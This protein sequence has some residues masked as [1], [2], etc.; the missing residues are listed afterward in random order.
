[1]EAVRAA[2]T[3]APERLTG[4]VISLNREAGWAWV[5]EVE[6]DPESAII[7]YFCHVRFV[8]EGKLRRGAR[9]TFVPRHGERGYFASDVKMIGSPSFTS[10]RYTVKIEG[11]VA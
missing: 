8:V 2:T 6:P 5:R 3:V 1:M 10:T 4:V 11:G 7:K 9:C